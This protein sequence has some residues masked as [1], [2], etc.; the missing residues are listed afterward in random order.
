[1]FTVAVKSTNIFLTG[2]SS[3]ILRIVFIDIANIA[4]EIDVFLDN[5]YKILENNTFRIDNF[6]KLKKALDEC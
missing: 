1:M 3:F 2:K 5:D 6:L 4:N